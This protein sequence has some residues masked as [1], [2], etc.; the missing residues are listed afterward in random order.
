MI[1]ALLLLPLLQFPESATESRPANDPKKI[2]S[3]VTS[4]PRIE[5]NYSKYQLSRAAK[6][7]TYF[8][9]IGRQ[10]FLCGKEDGAFEAWIWPYQIFHDAKFSFRPEKSLDGF[11]LHKYAN[12]ITVGAHQTTIHYQSA[13]IFVD[14]TIDCALGELSICILLNIDIDA[15]GTLI[16]SF[17]PKLQP[18]WPAARGGVAARWAPELGA[19]VISEPSAS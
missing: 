3:V 7:N 13:D 12:K 1:H 14:C 15:P 5:W 16:F 2:E 11:D 17:V 8:D 6:P 18:Q 9:A 4:V 10:A 19:F